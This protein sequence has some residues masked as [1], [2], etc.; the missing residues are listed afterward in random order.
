M[1]NSVGAFTY[2]MLTTV[3]KSTFKLL[4][5][6]SMVTITTNKLSCNTGIN[7]HFLKN[8]HI[9]R[10]THRESMQLPTVCSLTGL[11]LVSVAEHVPTCSDSVHAL[12][13]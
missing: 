13:Q 8:A 6:I 4:L 1:L 5:T 2:Q 11:L 3:N 12:H 7:S 9:I 10:E